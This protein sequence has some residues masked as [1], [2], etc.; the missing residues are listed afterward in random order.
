M[1]KRRSDKNTSTE[2]FAEE[3]NLRWDLHPF[4]LLCD[5]WKSST[6]N[7]GG[8]DDDCANIRKEIASNYVGTHSQTAATCRGKSYTE[9]SSSLPQVGFSMEDIVTEIYYEKQYPREESQI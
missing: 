6:S 1:D 2:M 3:E 5:N 7:G 8:E 4:D 9:P